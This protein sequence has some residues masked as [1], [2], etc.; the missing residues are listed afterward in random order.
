MGVTANIF[1]LLGEIRYTEKLS[2]M[3]SSCYYRN[4]WTE[5]YFVILTDF[6]FFLE[7]HCIEIGSKLMFWFQ[8]ILTEG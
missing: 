6:N 2:N 5:D 3:L 8:K 1:A 4:S 7:S